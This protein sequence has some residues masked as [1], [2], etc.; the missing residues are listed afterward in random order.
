MI[1]MGDHTL[2]A[3]LGGNH[4]NLEVA[5]VEVSREFLHSD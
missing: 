3:N 5:F 1:S 2:A 4:L